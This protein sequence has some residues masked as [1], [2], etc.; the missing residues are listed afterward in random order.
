MKI[1]FVRHGHPDYAKDALT[2][3]GHL[4]AEAVAE[5]LKDEPMDRIYS[6][7]N[8]RA[9]ETALYI[10]KKKGMPLT[11]KLDFMR[12]LDY[13]PLDGT[14]DWVTYNPWSLA[15]KMVGDNEPLLSN[16]TI[17]KDFSQSSTVKE[18]EKVVKGIDEF[19]ASL[20]YMREGNYYRVQ[21][22]TD[23][24]IV[25]VSHAGSSCAVISR[26][27]NLTLPFACSVFRWDFTGICEVNFHG[28]EGELITP[29]FGLTND[30][31]HIQGIK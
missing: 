19:L 3:L 28:T 17:R 31:R 18:V 24:T 14:H 23:E 11:E 2:E 4:Q 10:C 25:L 29:R 9:Y 12:E 21:K 1:I 16:W 15:D 6:S 20:G 27:F 7:S 5:R 30:S 26:L 22:A 13:R 8:G